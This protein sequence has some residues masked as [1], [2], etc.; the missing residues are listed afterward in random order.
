[1]EYNFFIKFYLFNNFINKKMSN[2][3]IILQAIKIGL[4]GDCTVGKTSVCKVF[5]GLEFSDEEMVTIGSDKFEKK[6]YLQNGKEIKLVLWDTAGQERF[7]SAAL[8][9]IRFVQ[10]IVIIFT[11]TN[12]RS[13]ENI[14]SWLKDIKENFEEPPLAL[15]GNM[16]DKDKERWEVTS[17][18]VKEFAKKN[19]LPYFETSA[20]TNQGL[21][22]G[23]SYIIEEVYRSI[24]ER[25][26]NKNI[27]IPKNNNNTS[28]CPG[29][30]KKNK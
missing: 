19:N 17:E 7:R 8:K 27:T 16:I 25:K 22:E 28:G 4:L 23:F 30:K 26:N 24:E 2:D 13:F 18:E 1:M 29:K 15:F 21:N 11:V 3:D 14:D 9:A 6:F 20:K 12:R 5:T 10:G